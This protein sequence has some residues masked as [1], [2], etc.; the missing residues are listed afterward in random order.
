M[1]PSF[2]AIHRI[3][4]KEKGKLKL[5]GMKRRVIISDGRALSDEQ[6]VEKLENFGIEISKD[7]FQ[8]MV[9]RFLSAEEMYHWY[10][11]QEHVQV[12]SN[13]DKDW[14]WICLDTG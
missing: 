8:Q 9:N 14:L 6:L 1:S 13:D 2:Y 5:K 10:F 12:K 4:D 7:T 11:D 3:Y